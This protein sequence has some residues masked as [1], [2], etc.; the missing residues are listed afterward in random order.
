MKTI[1]SGAILTAVLGFAVATAGGDEPRTFSGGPTQGA[2]AASVQSNTTSSGQLDWRYRWCDG[3]WWYWLPENRWVYY[4]GDRWVP[5]SG[6][7]TG[8]YPYTAA[9]GGESSVPAAMPGP[10][11]NYAAPRAYGGSSGNSGWQGTNFGTHGAAIS[12]GF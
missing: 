3:R 10:T 2:A 9:Y 8:A 6:V 5:Y 7:P 12:F 1:L 11:M 4:S